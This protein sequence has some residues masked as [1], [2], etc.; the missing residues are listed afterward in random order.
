MLHEQSALT[1]QHYSGWTAVG[2]KH[3]SNRMR[4]RCLQAGK[5]Y[6][7]PV[8]VLMASRVV[9]RIVG[10]FR[11]FVCF[12]KSERLEQSYVL[13][14]VQGQRAKDFVELHVAILV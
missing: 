1:E 4:S 13:V 8:Y 9:I 14:G 6:I 2:R 12:L 5:T 11:F 10:F 7:G 3:E